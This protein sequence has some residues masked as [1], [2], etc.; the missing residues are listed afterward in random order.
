MLFVMDQ[1]KVQNKTY[2]QLLTEL[3]G[4]WAEMP[5]DEKSKYE[6]AAVAAKK[7]YHDELNQW[8]L[9][10][11]AEGHNNMVRKSTLEGTTPSRLKATRITD[12]TKMTSSKLKKPMKDEEDITSAENPLT[13]KSSKKKGP[14]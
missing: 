11:M 4:P 2:P 9:K 13:S 3:K 7:Q 8:E 14:E 10:M 12:S 6:E 5:S 1:A